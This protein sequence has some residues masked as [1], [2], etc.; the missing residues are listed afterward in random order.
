MKGAV[1]R[2]G[3]SAFFANKEFYVQGRPQ[4]ECKNFQVKVTLHWD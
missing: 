1:P 2:E 3:S 4:K